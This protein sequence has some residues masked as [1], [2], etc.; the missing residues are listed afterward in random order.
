M[1]LEELLNELLELANEHAPQ[2]QTNILNVVSNPQ[3]LLGSSKVEIIIKTK[4]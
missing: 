2:P 3:E 1:T 4:E